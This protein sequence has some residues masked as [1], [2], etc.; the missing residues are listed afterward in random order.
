MN[1]AELKERLQNLADKNGLEFRTNDSS[2]FGFYFQGI[3]ILQLTDH[4]MEVWTK[5]YYFQTKDHLYNY[6]MTDSFASILSSLTDFQVKFKLQVE[7]LKN[8][9]DIELHTVNPGIIREEI[10]WGL[11]GRLTVS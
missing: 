10:G 4:I 5:I 1:L 8:E 9:L 2:W 11:N 6:C 3:R 7:N